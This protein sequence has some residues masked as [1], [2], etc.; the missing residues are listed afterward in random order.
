MNGADGPYDLLPDAVLRVDRSSG[1]IL[2]ANPAARALLG[3]EAATV[4]DILM[5]CLAREDRTRVLAEAAELD[6]GVRRRSFRVETPAGPRWI[7]VVAVAESLDVALLTGRDITERRDR[8]VAL[9]NIINSVA[10]PIFVKNER[11][12][13]TVLNDAACEF[14]GQSRKALIGRTDY[15]VFPHAEADEF[16]E[17]D[18]LVFEEHLETPHLNLESFTDSAGIHHTIATK[19]RAFVNRD[20]TKTL[21]GIIRDITELVQLQHEKDAFLANVS[22]ELRTPLTLMLAPLESMLAG[23]FGPLS[24]R[25]RHT[26][27]TMHNNAVRLLC[28]FF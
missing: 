13:W 28:I 17:K 14:I 3:A 20:G 9:D 24:D 26:S 8:E 7:E 25:L 1:R 19:K 5:G 10:D 18:R 2:H 4:N 6:R 22:H 27:E 23:D 21:V 15:D 16:R 11:F 12:E